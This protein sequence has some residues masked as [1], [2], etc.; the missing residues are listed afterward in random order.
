M[1]LSNKE[2]DRIGDKLRSNIVDEILLNKL[3]EF[4]S[5][6]EEVIRRMA[7]LCQRSVETIDENAI[8]VSRIKKFKT[9]QEKLIRYPST[10]LHQLHDVAGCRIILSRSEDLNRVRDLLIE[11]AVL[12]PNYK[13]KDYIANPKPN[14]YRGI[15]VI[16]QHSI[17]LRFVEVQIRSREQ[18]TWATLVETA[19]LVLNT[20]L[21]ESDSPSNVADVFEILSR[22]TDL[23]TESELSAV[24]SFEREYSFVNSIMNIY[25]ENIRN[26]EEVWRNSRPNPRKKAFILVVNESNSFEI[27]SFMSPKKAQLKYLERINRNYNENSAVIYSAK[28][29]LESILV[30]YSN[31]VLVGNELVL[32]IFEILYNVLKI[33][34]DKGKYFRFVSYYIDVMD[35]SS[36]EIDW[37]IDSYNKLYPFLS[38]NNER[39]LDFTSHQARMIRT[40]ELD[41]E[42]QEY[43]KKKGGIWLDL[44]MGFSKIWIRLNKRKVDQKLETLR[45][46][47][48]KL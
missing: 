24:L 3:A 38:N 16:F 45:Q 37:L 12:F 32:K 44:L 28:R 8:V 40:L 34:I 20:K 11:S 33:Q 6:H 30:G 15:H 36:L 14:G 19:D 2:I 48:F 17:D 26:V 27:Q 25:L 35:L 1:R 47:I 31:Y 7:E 18:H 42:L 43:C 46:I 9:I 10:K 23:L 41:R 21:K 5:S 4:R 39:K 22:D 13:I 29:D